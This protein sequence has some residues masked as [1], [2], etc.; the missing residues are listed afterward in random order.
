VILPSHHILL[1]LPRDEDD[2]RLNLDKDLSK[3]KEEEGEVTYIENTTEM[4][5]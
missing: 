4:K 3:E 1:D 2:S 5:T